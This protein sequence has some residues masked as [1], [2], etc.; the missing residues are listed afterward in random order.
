MV[1]KFAHF[2]ECSATGVPSRRFFFATPGVA[3]SCRLPPAARRA[4]KSIG[5][6][7]HLACKRNT[8]EKKCFSFLACAPEVLRGG[9]GATIEAARRPRAAAAAAGPGRKFF[10]GSVDSKKNRD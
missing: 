4:R 10:R 9:M 5:L 2:D 8:A 3:F 7:V 6:P 1:R